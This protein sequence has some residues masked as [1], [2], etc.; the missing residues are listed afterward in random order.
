[1]IHPSSKALAPHVEF[2]YTPTIRYFDCVFN[3]LCIAERPAP[4]PGPANPS[5]ILTTPRSGL[6]QVPYRGRRTARR[7]RA[8]PSHNGQCVTVDPRRRYNMSHQRDSRGIW[9]ARCFIYPIE[10]EATVSGKRRQ[11]ASG[12]TNKTWKRKRGEKTPSALRADRTTTRRALLHTQ[13]SDRKTPRKRGFFSLRRC[14][15][16]AGRGCYDRAPRLSK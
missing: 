4:T 5:V 16:H 15:A 3:V 1:M 12:I 7:D 11:A 10:T 9:H 8:K 14:K 6:L 13:A 2:I